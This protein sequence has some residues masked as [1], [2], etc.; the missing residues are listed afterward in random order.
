[1]LSTSIPSVN[2]TYF[3]HKVLSKIHGKPEYESL[4]L[5]ATELKANAG[6]VPSTGGG[7]L[8]GHLGMILSAPR[9][10][11]LAGTVPWV[12]P[13]NPGPYEPPPPPGTAA[14]IE[15]ARDVWRGLHRAFEVAQATEKA[16]IAQI[17]ESIDSIY[18][19]ALLNRVTGHRP[20]LYEHACHARTLVHDLW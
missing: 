20:V 16:L 14:Q 3:Q 18:I 10:A 19:R 1:M 17:V 15:A 4:Q 11:T 2:D 6:S 5:L 12:P 13:A 8:H 9:Y 7:G